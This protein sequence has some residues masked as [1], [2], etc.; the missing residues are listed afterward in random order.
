MKG[1]SLPPDQRPVYR[2]PIP[3]KLYIYK[4]IMTRTNIFYILN[5]DFLHYYSSQISFFLPTVCKVAMNRHNCLVLSFR[6]DSIF[7]FL[8]VGVNPVFVAAFLFEV[9]DIRSPYLRRNT[10]SSFDPILPGILFRWLFKINHA[11]SRYCYFDGKIHESNRL[12]FLYRSRFW[13]WATKGRFYPGNSNF[14]VAITTADRLFR[15]L[16][17]PPPN[18]KSTWSPPSVAKW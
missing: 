18:S 11:V 1:I 16:Q 12:N 8:L 7:D 15:S 14:L 13:S 17:G 3:S 10:S 4:Y 2:V 5:I 6:N 9:S